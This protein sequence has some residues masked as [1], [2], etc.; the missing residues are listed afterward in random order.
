MTI[1]NIQAIDVKVRHTDTRIVKR[2]HPSIGQWV[3]YTTR[4]ISDG[5]LHCFVA[6]KK[7]ITKKKPDVN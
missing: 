4:F 3:K 5:S 6:F 7:L 2:H 1:E